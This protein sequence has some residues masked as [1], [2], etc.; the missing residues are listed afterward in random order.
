[1]ATAT[2]D[3]EILSWA[4]VDW[5]LDPKRFHKLAREQRLYAKAQLQEAEKIN[6]ALHMT[7]QHSKV[8]PLKNNLWGCAFRSWGEYLRMYE[9][10]L[11][12]RG[13]DPE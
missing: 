6:G 11:L 2:Q 12:F 3:F 8:C 10:N 1:M 5:P 4:G 7:G 13:V 9:Q